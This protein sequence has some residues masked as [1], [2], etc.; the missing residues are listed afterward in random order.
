MTSKERL[1]RYLAGESVD[2]RPNLTIVGSVVTQYTGISVEEY[3]K[4]GKKMAESAALAADDLRLDYIQVASDL[5]REAEGF[6]SELSF[7]PDKL[8]NV[9]KPAIDD[10]A[11]VAGL[12][13]LNVADVRRLSDLVEATAY[14]K[15]LRTDVEPMTLVVGPATVAGNIRG[16]QDLLVDL[17]DDEE[18]CRELFT[19]TT[20]TAL[21][22]IR[23]LADVG[24]TALYVADPVASLLSPAQYREM[25]LPCH[26]RIFAEMAKFGMHSRLHMCGNT[27]A[28]L[29]DSAGCGAQILD[30]DHAVDFGKALDAAAGRCIL[31]GNI[32]PVA[33]VFSCDAAHTKAKMLATAASVGNARAMFMPGCELPTK[34]PLKNVRAIADALDEIGG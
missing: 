34:T 16:M 32:D 25:I 27:E 11:D 24:A 28:I 10:I 23:A 17:Y 29:P 3:C 2:R 13:P 6:G 19:I 33:D 9:H 15:T 21:N 4:N 30:I 7:F 14:A 5:A 8:P 22:L 12:R 18:A 31:N 20:E 1:S 26:K